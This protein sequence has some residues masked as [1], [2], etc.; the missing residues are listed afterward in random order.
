MTT[1]NSCANCFDGKKNVSSFNI[2]ERSNTFPHYSYCVGNGERFGCIKQSVSLNI[3]LSNRLNGI[4]Q[5]QERERE[6][7]E[8]HRVA[9]KERIE[10]LRMERKQEYLERGA[11]M[12]KEKD[13]MN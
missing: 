2:V 4:R 5:K 11:T 13:D 8:N 9:Q 6:R 1:N 10:K 3:I 7:E 12:L